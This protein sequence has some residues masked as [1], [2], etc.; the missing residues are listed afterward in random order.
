MGQLSPKRTWQR[1]AGEF[2]ELDKGEGWPFAI[3][4]ACSVKKGSPG[5]SEASRAAAAQASGKATIVQFAR[6]AGTDVGRVARHLEAWDAAAAQGHCPSSSDLTPGDV[7]TLPYPA[8]DWKTHYRDNNAAENARDRTFKAKAL[9]RRSA[10]ELLA[11]PEVAAAVLGST[12]GRDLVAKEARKVAAEN[13]RRAAELDDAYRKGEQHRADERASK[14]ADGDEWENHAA[15]AE[16]TGQLARA[17]RAINEAIVEA[18]DSVFDTD[19]V[20]VI[21]DRIEKLE[22]ATGLL[23]LAVTGTLGVDWDA[24]LV[25]LGDLT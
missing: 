21:V 9:I 19:H 10:D 16:V 4:V 23:R 15:F 17:R 20:E 24:E 22:A 1:N 6:L 12:T 5:G 18:R 2:A 14:K 11:D 13:R 7:D 8:V 3:L 25:K